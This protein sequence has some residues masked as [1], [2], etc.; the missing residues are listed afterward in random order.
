MFNPEEATLDQI[1]AAFDSEEL[2]SFDLTAW[3]ME[4]IADIDQS[5][6]K[7]NSVI[8]INPEAL[9][10]AEA[11]DRERKALGKRSL[12]HGVPVLV[13]DCINTHD[14]MHTSSG[15]IA[16]ANN[17]A[18]YDATVVQRLREAGA[19]LLGKTNM[20]EFANYMTKQMKNGYSSKGGQVISPYNPEGNVWG[21]SSGS[22]VAVS[23]NLCSVALGT[24]TN[25][26][27]IWPSHNNAVV[28]IKPTLGSVSRHGIIPISTAQ[29]IAGPIARTVADAATLLGIIAGYDENDASTWSR[30]GQICNDYARCFDKDGL[31][32]LRVGV[33]KGTY[34]EL[35]AEQKGLA[36]KAYQVL[37]RCGAELIQGL[38]LPRLRCDREILFYEFKQSLNAYLSTCSPSLGINTLKDI[39]DANNVRPD[40]AL[41][42]GQTIL[43][44][45]E[46]K[47]SGRLIEPDYLRNRS[48]Y[49]KKSRDEGIDR[50]MKEHN[51]EIYVTPGIS[52]ASP[53]SGYPSIVVPIG[54]TGD[55]MPFG[56][57]F[58]GKPFSEP[59]LIQAAYAFEQEM[60]GRKAPIFSV[61]RHE[62]SETPAWA[63]TSVGK[64][65]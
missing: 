54:F 14:K 52:D 32:G 18:P 2:S 9:F 65:N 38:S 49:L 22:A 27:I 4:R 43:L 5:G 10:I 34:D 40:L 33:N 44:D 42:Y 26:S 37:N 61:Q 7:L 50:M 17:F 35:S 62:S 23:A 55:H 39:I 8:E 3:Y 64:I 57:T 13:K 20:T 59:L 15:S 16:L 31:N 63:S 12:L 1:Q 24:E 47:T 28:G 6:P 11:M 25:G 21:S 56:L 60:R 45:V 19:V 58:V 29:D 30:E 51:V 48:A 46:H 36:E 53:I 41:K